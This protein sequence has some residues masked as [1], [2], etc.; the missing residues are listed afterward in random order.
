MLFIAFSHIFKAQPTSCLTEAT[1][2]STSTVIHSNFQSAVSIHFR[3]R[4][5]AL[6]RP[7]TRSSERKLK[8]WNGGVI[9]NGKRD[10]HSTSHY[11]LKLQPERKPNCY[12]FHPVPSM[13]LSFPVG[14]RAQRLHSC[15]STLPQSPSDQHAMS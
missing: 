10:A 13:C 14:M 15:I 7:G 12:T 3:L 11:F 6:G 5:V 1:P 9:K 8:K 4:K 2:S